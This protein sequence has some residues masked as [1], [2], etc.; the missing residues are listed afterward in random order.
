MWVSAFSLGII[1]LAL[2]FVAQRQS[3]P[4]H[5]EALS[6]A[7]K[8]LQG[9][10]IRLPLALLAAGFI[11]ELLPQQKVIELVGAG[12]GFNGILVAS[13]LGSILPGGPM[14]SFPLAIVLF[15][16][17]AG[18]AQMVALLT[19]W[20]VLAVHRI[21]AFELSMIGLPF[22]AR[23]LVVSLPLPIIAGLIAQWITSLD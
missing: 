12:S 15:D 20:S 4:P 22:V 1:L 10:L 23:R 14:V 11:A 18:S 5:R 16:A 3:E 19:A 6:T 21:L 8:Q 17:G 9:L 13:L 2:L 7:W